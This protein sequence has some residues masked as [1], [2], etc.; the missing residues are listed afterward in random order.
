MGMGEISTGGGKTGDKM[1]QVGK[2]RR[3][4]TM[5]GNRDKVSMEVRARAGGSP[6]RP[7]ILTPSESEGGQTP[8]GSRANPGVGGG[9]KQRMAK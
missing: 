9:M 1:G 2:E 8:P 3:G 4:G 6:H 7:P 5:R